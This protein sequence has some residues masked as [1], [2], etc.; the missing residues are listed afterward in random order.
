L[1][2]RK[3]FEGFLIEHPQSALEV[4]R[5]FGA[6]LR[7]T[8]LLVSQQAKRNANIVQEQSLS[9][10]DRL[11]IAIT[12]KVGSIGF[13]LIIAGWTLLWTGYKI[14]ASEVPALHWPAFGPFPAFVA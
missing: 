8:N 6:R 13:F 7:Q 9:A 11:A 2:H 10:L 14:L 1:L 3:D 12:N 4:I 5:G